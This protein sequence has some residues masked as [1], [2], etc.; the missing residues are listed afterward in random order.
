M[1]NIDAP[2]F[3][4]RTLNING[5]KIDYCFFETVVSDDKVSNFLVKSLVKIINEASIFDNLIKLIKNNLYNSNIK[6]LKDKNEIFYYL[7]SGFTCIFIKGYKEYIVVETRET[8]DRGITEPTSEVNIKGPKDSFTENHNKNIGLIRKRLKDPNLIIKDYRIGARSKSKVSVV[9]INDIVKIEYVKKIEEKLKSINTDAILDAGYI[10]D[11]LTR[12]SRSHFPT[13]VNTERPDTVCASLLEGKIA[14]LVE[15]TPFVLVI[16]GFLNNFLHAVEDSYQKANNITM[17]RILRFMAL[18]ITILAPAFYVA[19]TTYNQEVIP[20]KLLISL[21]VQRAGVPF[22]TSFEVLILML[23]FEILRESD[24]RL[25]ESMGTSISI[26]GA[27]VLGDAA[28]SAGI[29]SPI[30]VIVV[31]ISSITGLL[32]SDMDVVNALRWWKLIFLM[33]STFLG[34]V[35]FVIAFIL[36]VTK[37]CSVE[38]LGI[39][40]LTPF[41][42]L[43]IKALKDSFVAFPK[44][45]MTTRAAYLTKNVK[46]G[47]NNEN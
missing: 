31:A 24:L 33:F 25:P 46:R 12:D 21:A 17:T 10:R 34:L 42:P 32:F 40:Y 4:K 14:I 37:L 19:I 27:L 1:I 6:V 9:Y 29:V 16:P 47:E 38:V 18:L 11:F 35:G 22:P 45:K 28:V 3:I 5:K 20:D 39:P 36:F 44:N 13:V 26:V 30:V 2:D 7:S 41:S 8:L 43:D 23:T 15:N